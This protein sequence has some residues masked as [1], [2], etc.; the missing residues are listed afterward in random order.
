MAK[1]P[2]RVANQ[3]HPVRGGGAAGPV[4]AA[5][6]KAT[7]RKAAP[8]KK[9]AKAKKPAKARAWSPDEVMPCCSARAVAESLRIASG[10]VLS[11]QDV[12]TLHGYAGGTGN[13]SVS[14]WDALSAAQGLFPVTFEPVDLDD[15]AAVILGL[16][17]PEPHAVAVGLDGTW[18]SWGQPYDVWHDAVIDEAWAVTW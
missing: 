3:G 11:D 14:I 1:R 12:L 15:P 6:K 16:T 7:V 2:A 13:R 18:W 8:A 5:P 17:I 9:T 4:K 10:P